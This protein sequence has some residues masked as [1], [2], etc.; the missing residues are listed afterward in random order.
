MNRLEF[1]KEMYKRAEQTAYIKA[2]QIAQEGNPCSV[3]LFEM[4]LIEQKNLIFGS[5]ITGLA[6]DRQV[7]KEQNLNKEVKNGKLWS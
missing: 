5:L 7:F 4:E 2:L 3:I 1:R 6:N